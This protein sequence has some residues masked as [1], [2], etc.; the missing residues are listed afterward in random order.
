MDF[1]GEN[2]DPQ[3]TCVVSLSAFSSALMPVLL[4]FEM[5]GERERGGVEFPSCRR[6]KPSRSQ[7]SPIDCSS[8][9]TD[10]MVHRFSVVEMLV[11]PRYCPFL[12]GSGRDSLIV[13]SPLLV[14]V[15]LSSATPSPTAWNEFCVPAA[16]VKA[17]TRKPLQWW[18]PLKLLILTAVAE[19]SRSSAFP[20]MPV[21]TVQPL[22]VLL[23]VRHCGPVRPRPKPCPPKRKPSASVPF[24]GLI[25]LV[26]PAEKPVAG[27][28]GVVW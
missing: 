9:Q 10:E 4:S 23:G 20:M 2:P 24:H 21:F 11:N 14:E 15:H 19:P 28:V 18:P 3:Y 25:L 6:P 13:F 5:G 7:R 16:M 17:K 12:K 8:S 27:D 22:I 1:L 26:S